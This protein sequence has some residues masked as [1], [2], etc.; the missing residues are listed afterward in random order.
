MKTSLKY[1]T[2]T[3]LA[4]TMLTWFSLKITAGE[5]EDARE[6]KEDIDARE[7]FRRL[8]LQDENGQ[9]PPDAWENAY[10]EKERMQFLPE[11]WSEFSTAAQVAAGIAGGSWTSIG[12]GNIG[13]RIRSIIIK[14]AGTPDA[15]TI[16]VGAVSGGVWKSTDSGLNWSTNTDSLA[17]TAVNCM[18]IDPVNSD[19]LYAGTGEG[20]SVGDA[21]RGNGI[22]KT[23]R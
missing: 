3:G 13:G 11:A 2:I 5:V 20:F 4:L 12:P 1:L 17:N 8:Q 21:V 22:F 9:I 18:A 6:T 23:C 10:A 16:W 7:A 19:I 14:P 15:R